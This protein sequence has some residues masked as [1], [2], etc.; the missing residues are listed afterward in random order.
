[1]YIRYISTDTMHSHMQNHHHLLP[2]PVT[3]SEPLGGMKSYCI[4]MI[5]S[6][7]FFCPSVFNLVAFDSAANEAE[8]SPPSFFSDEPV[9][10]MVTPPLLTTTRL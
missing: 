1:M 2:L 4:S 10:P 9:Q 7:S 3:A 5:R 6:A 8:G